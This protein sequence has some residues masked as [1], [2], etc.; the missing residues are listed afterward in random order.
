VACSAR[1]M[2]GSSS[3]TRIRPSPSWGVVVFTE[4]G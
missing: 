3:T 2:C 1:R 4:T